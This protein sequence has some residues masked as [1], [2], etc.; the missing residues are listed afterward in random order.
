MS[1]IAATFDLN[2]PGQSYGHLVVPYSNNDHAYSVI[3]VPVAVL[4]GTPGPTVLL[5]AG[6][7]GDK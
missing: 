1:R 5:A 4:S 7:H 3:S 2:A 6:T